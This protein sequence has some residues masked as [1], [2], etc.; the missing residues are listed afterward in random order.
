MKIDFRHAVVFIFAAFFLGIN[1]SSRAADETIPRPEHPRPDR[2]RSDW[3]NLNGRWE[4]AFD[5]ENRGLDEKWSERESLGGGTILVPFAP[6]SP[7]SGI[8][9][10]E[11]HRYCWYARSFDVPDALL[12][13]RLLLHFGAVDYRAEVWLNG[14]RLGCHDGGYDSFSFDVADIVRP[15][16]N[17]LVLRIEDD[18][19]VSKPSGKQSPERNPSGCLYMRV[20]GIWQTVWLE[21]VGESYI[22]DWTVTA[23]PT[24]GRAL[25]NLR[26]NGSVEGLTLTAALSLHG[27]ESASVS[28]SLDSSAEKA[29]E[30]LRTTAILRRPM[31]TGERFAEAALTVSDPVAWTP[32]SPVLYD[33]T[34]RLTDSEN[35][36]VD[37][38]SSY[39]GFRTIRVA[40]GQYYLNDRPIFFASAL[41]QGYNA[42]GLYT[43][44]TDAFQREDVLWAKRYGLNGIRKH[45]IIPEPRF[46]YWCDL[47]GL[48]VWA[49]M[50]DWGI[51]MSAESG[52]SE[53]EIQGAMKSFAAEWGRCLKQQ[54]NHPSIITWVVTNEMKYPHEQAIGK[55]KLENYERTKR[56]D[57]SRPVVDN[58]GY[59]HTKTDI[60]DLHANP[61]GEAPWSQW[62]ERWR[63]SIEATGNFD[64][65]EN[66][67]TYDDG[68]Q[69]RGEPVIISETGNW[70]IRS[71]PPNGPWP[72]YGAGPFETPDDFLR[73]YRAY[74]TSLIAEPL[75]SGFSYVQL[76]DV[77]GEVNGYLTYDRRP[78]IA[79]EEI[80]AIHAEG[81]KLRRENKRKNQ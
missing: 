32:E 28:V 74:F 23:D 17:R 52:R 58:S 62:A 68:F 80:R 3:L 51:N 46:Y 54:I 37:S 39:V 75:L 49:E 15:T 40:D 77:E 76:Y 60:V 9:D 65:W 16:G 71:L 78:K 56:L 81:L 73:G 29:P 10:E 14:E 72:A 5:P 12:S 42:E 64:V 19:A 43:P 55:F 18:P 7:K 50:P 44:P 31:S 13:R 27:L 21:A 2:Y 69:Y 66:S 8:H 25:L 59:S 70:H 1:F 6:E 22:D 35:R 41:D 61:E 20:T 36:L 4:F 26:V 48:M 67:P 53:K 63:K 79:P 11:F 45:Q 47:L 30:V 38:V 34:L 24:T 57:P 33:L